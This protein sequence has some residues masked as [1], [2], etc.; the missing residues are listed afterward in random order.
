ML[1]MDFV[2][3]MQERGSGD[4]FLLFFCRL[5]KRLKKKKIAYVIYARD[6]QDKLREKGRNKK[7][8]QLESR[9]ES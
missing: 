4:P 9:K 6:C 5:L 1:R 3:S 2:N 7:N 8:Q